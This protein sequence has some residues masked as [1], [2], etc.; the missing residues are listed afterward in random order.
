MLAI[1]ENPD[2]ALGSLLDP[3][4]GLLQ[5]AVAQAGQRVRAALDQGDLV[6]C[7]NLYIGYLSLALLAGTGARPIRDPLES[8]ELIDHSIGF[9]YLDDK[10]DGRSHQ[11]R[12]APLPSSLGRHLAHRYPV[13]LGELAQSLAAVAPALASEVAVLAAGQTSGR[14]PYLFLLSDEPGLGWSSVSK[15]RVAALGLFNCPLS[16]YLFRH[17]F[18]NRLR[19]QRVS[20]EIIDGYMGHAEAGLVS[21]GD[22]SPRCWSAD[23]AAVAA[24]IDDAFDAL[25]F[26]LEIVPEPARMALTVHS[27]TGGEQDTLGSAPVRFGAEARERE[28]YSRKRVA[29]RNA[30]SQIEAF[31][32][33]RALTDLSP[34]E[35]DR[36]SRSLLFKPSGLPRP[37]GFL[38]YEYLMR[39]FER[40]WKRKGNWVRIRRRHFPLANVASPFR[41]TAPG[42]PQ[43]LRELQAVVRS[44]VAQ[45]RPSRMGRAQC[46]GVGVVSLCVENRIC[47]PLLLERLLAGRD[48]RLVSWRNTPYLEYAPE[49][50][51]DDPA[52]P[53]Q[54][55]RIGTRTAVL[56]DRALASARGG[57]SADQTAP[58]EFAQGLGS[59]LGAEQPPQGAAATSS[60][61]CGPWSTRPTRFRSPASW[62]PFSPGACPRPLCPGGTG[63]VSMVV[64]RWT[65]RTPWAAVPKRCRSLP[66]QTSD[67]P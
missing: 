46:L 15:T 47:D 51:V 24:A 11:G 8:P 13:Y 17:R 57:R 54:R 23:R 1:P 7:H 25:G 48:F 33:G 14:L 28:R 64:A 56:L 45:A 16:A 59:I 50:V 27:D 26:D 9:I 31:C 21:Y 20:P 55:Y 49:L 60:S 62:Q 29:L 37:T 10:S 39:K 34:E 43:R 3:L 35:I 5:E 67:R 58:S 65:S 53:V 22:L 42:A 18:A 63:C 44:F 19:D 52:A 40:A 4:E 41:P 38:R 36:L 32:S 6:R 66:C 30:Q 61:G 2:N 12:L